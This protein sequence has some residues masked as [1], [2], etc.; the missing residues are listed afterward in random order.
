MARSEEIWEN[1]LEILLFG[2]KYV[3]SR[4]FG[5]A[6]KCI[7]IYF[8]EA[9]SKGLS[10]GLKNDVD[11]IRELESYFDW[12]LNEECLEYN[13]CKNYQPFLDAHKVGF[14]SDDHFTRNCSF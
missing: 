1:S 12:A 2:N 6:P 3:L 13:E 8:S 11:Q 9:H 4:G 14:A 7:N 5:L 10:V